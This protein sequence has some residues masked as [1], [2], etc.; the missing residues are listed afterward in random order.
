MKLWFVLKCTLLLSLA[1]AHAQTPQAPADIEGYRECDSHGCC[2]PGNMDERCAPTEFEKVRRILQN[3]LQQWAD[4]QRKKLE[5]QKR[6][7]PQNS[8]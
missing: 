5:E 1:S 3:E 6:R 4:E 2:F 7:D 8:N